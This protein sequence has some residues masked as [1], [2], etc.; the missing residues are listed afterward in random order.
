[1][2]EGERTHTLLVDGELV[3]VLGDLRAGVDHQQPC[4]GRAGQCASEGLTAS[5]RSATVAVEGTE[6]ESLRS[7]GPLMLSVNW[8]AES[9][10][11]RCELC[12]GW[13]E[14]EWGG[15]D[16]ARRLSPGPSPPRA[17]C[18]P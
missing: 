5:L 15:G 10:M 3:L 2:E 18:L 9:A 8:S 13:S 12:G 1:V 7:L 16:E 6:T 4:P 17:R 11:V 14:G